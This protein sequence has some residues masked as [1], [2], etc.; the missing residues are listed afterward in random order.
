M[1]VVFNLCYA[2]LIFGFA[3]GL[4][5]LCRTTTREQD[6]RQAL[7]KETHLGYAPHPSDRRHGEN[8]VTTAQLEAIYNL[9][10]LEPGFDRLRQAIRDEQ[11]KGDH[12]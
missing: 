10:E 6:A 12:S 9:P 1:T 7:L 5:R 3:L 4:W 8:P 2:A 11:Q